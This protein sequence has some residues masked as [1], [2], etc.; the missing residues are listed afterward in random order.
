MGDAVS[1][2]GGEI[3]KFIGDAMLAIFPVDEDNDRSKACAAAL[4]AGYEALAALADLNTRRREANAPE[5]D[6]GIGLHVGDVMYGNIGARD[7][8]DFT[9]IGPAVN[10]ATRIEDLCRDLTRPLLASA[11]FAAACE[12]RLEP[13]GAQQLHGI[14]VEHEIYA[15]AATYTFS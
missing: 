14:E 13:I 15:P 2:R 8:L 10:L 1:S 5:I 3:L 4:D 11:E 6:V 7:R 9:V 12:G